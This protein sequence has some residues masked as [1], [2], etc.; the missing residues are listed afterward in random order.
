MD[1]PPSAVLDLADSPAITSVRRARV[2]VSVVFAAHGAVYGSFATRIPWLQDRLHLGPGL[3][4]VGLLAPSVGA[5]L[6]M[7][8]ASR[9]IHRFGG[10]RATRAMIAAWCIAGALP[11]FAPNLGVLIVFLMAYGITSGTADIAM[12]AQAIPI[13]KAAG[14]SIMSGLH[15]MWSLGGVIGSAVGAAA[16]HANLDARIHL[17]ATAVVLASVAVIA[18]TSLPVNNTDAAE[19]APARFAI[20]PRPV[21]L[22]GLLAF[23]GLFV[24]ASS[25]DWCAVYLKKVLHTDPG[26]AATAY[27]AFAFTMAGVRVGGD[28]AIRAFGPARTV[29]VSGI[30]GTAGG[31]LVVLAINT[32]VTIVGFALIGLGIAV[33]FPLA[34]AAAGHADAQPARAIAGVATIAWGAGIAAPGIVGGV[35]AASSLPTSFMLITALIAVV[36]VGAR[37]LQPKASTDD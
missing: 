32:P 5:L 27:T 26:I 24:E 9:L 19:D 25:S 1:H 7:P 35:A 2:A 21:I 34:F 23:C 11:V 37:L 10:R 29:R 18:A 36:A 4:G 22:L 17:T 12:N 30:I 33:V 16:A 3:L 6:G 8:F 28:Y 15:G 13:E 31:V 14:K 20:P